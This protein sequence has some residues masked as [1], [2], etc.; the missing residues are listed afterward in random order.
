MQ[1]QVPSADRL[2]AAAR[3]VQDAAQPFADTRGSVE[4][5][6]DLVRV[7][8]GRAMQQAVGRAR[9]A[10]DRKADGR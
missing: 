7:L 5:K 10:E 3:L 8:V 9:G 1:A 6:R 2:D 4:Y